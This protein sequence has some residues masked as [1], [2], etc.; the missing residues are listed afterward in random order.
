MAQ[1][2]KVREEWIHD[3]GREEEGGKSIHLCLQLLGLVLRLEGD[4][5]V[6]LG[7]AAPV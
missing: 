7:A 5:P 6:T 3:R 1:K 4:E 2:T